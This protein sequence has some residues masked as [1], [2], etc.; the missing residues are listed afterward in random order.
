MLGIGVGIPGYGRGPLLLKRLLALG[1]ELALLPDYGIT[2]NGS[3]VAAQADQSGNAHDFA[4]ATEDDQ[5]TLTNGEIIYY[6]TDTRLVSAEAASTWTFLH[7]PA[8]TIAVAVRVTGTSQTAYL[9]STQRGA[10]ATHGFHLLRNSSDNLVYQVSNGSGTFVVNATS[11]GGIITNGLSAVIVARIGEGEADEYSVRLNGTSI[12]SGA[13]VGS[14]SATAPVG[15][16][17]IG[18]LTLGTTSS[19][20]GAINHVLAWDRYLST[21]E[22]QTVEGLL[23][24]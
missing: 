17:T 5:P 20:D 14:P 18:D 8:A 10:A 3:D 21:A 7:G 11:T 1:P 16:L 12:L 22:C 13:L 2:L 6:G 23:A 24:A 4:Q 9:M 15:T 19:W